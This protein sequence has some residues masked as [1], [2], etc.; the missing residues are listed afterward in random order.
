MWLTFTHILFG[1]KILQATFLLYIIAYFILEFDDKLSVP[2][3]LART[4]AFMTHYSAS[5]IAIMTFYFSRRK[6]VIAW[7]TL[8]SLIV[9][10]MPMA[11][12]CTTFDSSTAWTTLA[13]DS[14]AAIARSTSFNV[15]SIGNLNI[16]DFILK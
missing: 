7:F 15:R 3:H 10:F 16:H 6:T 13:S 5:K 14:S 1:D 11:A 9:S 2:S 8:M 4:F 12:T